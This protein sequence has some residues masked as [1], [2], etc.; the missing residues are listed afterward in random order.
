[1]LKSALMTTAY[2]QVV[3]RATARAADPFDVGAGH[4]DPNHAIDPGLVYENE[5]R[6]HAAYL[7]GLLA[8]RRFPATA[9]GTRRPG[10]RASA[11]T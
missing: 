11:R 8:T 6:D 2:Q 5:F 7:C 4:I 10:S 3:T 1:M 9:P